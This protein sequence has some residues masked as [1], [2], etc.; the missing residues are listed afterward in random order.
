MD[1]AKTTAGLGL[2]LT[3]TP[4]GMPAQSANPLQV[5]TAT[6]YKSL[7]FSQV[8]DQQQLA[9]DG[10]PGELS[11]GVVST[12]AGSPLWWTPAPDG[13][14]L[15]LGH[16][17]LPLAEGDAVVDAEGGD[18]AAHFVW[19]APVPAVSA[20][21]AESGVA[22]DTNP[23]TSG[24]EPTVLGSRAAGL[25]TADS[26]AVASGVAAAGGGVGTTSSVSAAGVGALQDTPA[27]TAAP[28]YPRAST[29]DTGP[30]A[31]SPLQSATSTLEPASRQDPAVQTP[32][33][34]AS[35]TATPGIAAGVGGAPDPGAAAGIAAAASGLLKNGVAAAERLVEPAAQPAAMTA[36]ESAGTVGA[37]SATHTAPAASHTPLPP[38]YGPAPEAGGHLN[39][40]RPGW[41]EAVVDKLM[42][43]SARQLG[44]AEIQLDP[45]EL[46]P[47][48]LRVSTQ[49]DQ[50]SV[51]FS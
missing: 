27:N 51:S 41:G 20:P 10:L 33:P 38:S 4:A 9:A 18:S 47:L 35:A 12:P 7:V 34:V 26:G 40:Q 46:G 23:K 15:P 36:L 45:P 2:L 32:G 19:W 30:A 22:D 1:T 48:Q 21:A 3:S 37:G 13:K 8:L 17:G 44:S 25:S 42:W 11:T 50:T 5:S 29:A 39:M 49:H 14:A 6:P 16:Q 24:P 43:M 31:G 28:G